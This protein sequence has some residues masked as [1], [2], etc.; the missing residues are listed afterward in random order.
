VFPYVP[1]PT[2]WYD[3]AR[4]QA[5]GENNMRK[6]CGPMRYFV[7]GTIALVVVVA[8]ASILPDLARYIK[9]SSM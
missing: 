3:L 2:F 8:G 4:L 7:I 5:K 1:Y 9:I 6:N